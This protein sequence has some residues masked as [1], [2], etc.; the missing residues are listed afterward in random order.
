[1]FRWLRRRRA[2]EPDPAE[3]LR[4]KLVESRAV[5]EDRDEFESGETPVDRADPEAQRAPAPEEV[6]DESDPEAQRAPAPEEVVDESDPEARRR[7]VH[8]QTRARIDELSG[9]EES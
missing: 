4:A 9:R 8:D 2:T 5:A 6:V 1:V 7:G 3:A